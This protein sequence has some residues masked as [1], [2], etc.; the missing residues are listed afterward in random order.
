[1]IEYTYAEDYPAKPEEIEKVKDIIEQYP[2]TYKADIFGNGVRLY[3]KGKVSGK[4]Y[5]MFK[6]VNLT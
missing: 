6:E 5:R 1:M 2:S 4:K 3:Y